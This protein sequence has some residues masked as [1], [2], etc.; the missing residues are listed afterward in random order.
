GFR[1]RRDCAALLAARSARGTRTRAPRL[2]WWSSCCSLRCLALARVCEQRGEVARLEVVERGDCSGDFGRQ[3]RLDRV[4][5]EAP[6][7]FLRLIPAHRAG[8]EACVVSL[9]GGERRAVDEVEAQPAGVF[10]GEAGGQVSGGP[11]LDAT[12]QVLH[13]GAEDPL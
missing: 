11:H 6:E 8:Q 12:Q 5:G 13:V 9:V 7:L 10:G 1:S 3:L 2:S 4:G